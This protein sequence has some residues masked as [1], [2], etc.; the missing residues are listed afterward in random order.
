MTVDLDFDYE[1]CIVQYIVT[2]ISLVFWLNIS[3]IN[4]HF[5]LKLKCIIES[6]LVLMN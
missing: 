2:D 1:L 6:F 4:I 3:E 5:E